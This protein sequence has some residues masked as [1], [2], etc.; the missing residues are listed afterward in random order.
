VNEDN[1][2]PACDNRLPEARRIT[3]KDG[4]YL[5]FFEFD[6]PRGDEHPADEVDED[7]V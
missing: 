1:T 3:L 4:R 6:E 2:K 7:N 5:I